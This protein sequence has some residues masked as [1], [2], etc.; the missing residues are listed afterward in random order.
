[1][2][3]SNYETT[4][5][6]EAVA[7]VFPPYQDISVY[8]SL[9]KNDVKKEGNDADFTTM[10]RVQLP[11]SLERD[12]NTIFLTKQT[13]G[14][15]KKGKD[16]QDA[17]QAIK[18]AESQ[19][20]F[21]DGSA[22]DLAPIENKKRRKNSPPAGPVMTRDFYA[23]FAEYMAK[24]SGYVNGSFHLARCLVS[25]SQNLEMARASNNLASKNNL[26][27]YFQSQSDEI[28][29]NIKD[30][31]RLDTVVNEY[32]KRLIAANTHVMRPSVKHKGGIDVL[33]TGLPPALPRDLRADPELSA[34]GTP[35]SFNP[36][37]AN[38]NVPVLRDATHHGMF[39]DPSN[40]KYVLPAGK[41]ALEYSGSLIRA[42]FGEGAGTTATAHQRIT[43][44][45]PLD[46]D[47][48]A[49]LREQA[50]KLRGL[51]IDP[52]VLAED[53][54]SLAGAYPPEVK[55]YIS[56]VAVL[57][58]SPAALDEK[59]IGLIDSEKST[60]S[61]EA[62]VLQ[63]QISFSFVL[64][65]P[66]E[67]VAFITQTPTNERPSFASLNTWV[68]LW[69]KAYFKRVGQKGTK[70]ERANGAVG[71]QPSKVPRYILSASQAKRL[72]EEREKLG[73][74]TEDGRSNDDHIFI[75]NIG[76]LNYLPK[77]QDMSVEN[78]VNYER[79]MDEALQLAFEAGAP[80]QMIGM[81][82]EAHPVFGINHPEFKTKR[83]GFKDTIDKYAGA[84]HA[85]SW[86]YNCIIV[87]N[88]GEADKTKAIDLSGSAAPNELSL[89]DY[90]RKP[91]GESMHKLFIMSRVAKVDKGGS[92]MVTPDTFGA[93][94]Q[95]SREMID[96]ALP[97]VH[98][99]QLYTYL[100]S[101][102]AVPS[103]QELVNRAASDMRVTNLRTDENIAKFESGFGDNQSLYSG[104]MTADLVVAAPFN[105]QQPAER[106]IE[107]LYALFKRAIIDASGLQGTNLLRVSAQ[108]GMDVT[109]YDRFFSPMRHN[110]HEFKNVY[111]YF[112]GRVFMH[113]MKAL[114]EADKKKMMV[115]NPSNPNKLLPYE[116]IVSEVMP[117]ATI[118]SK[119]IPNSDQIMIKGD[120]LAEKNRKN[121]SISEEDIIVP[122]SKAPDAG[123]PNDPEAKPGMQMFPHQ[124][125]GHKYLRNAPKFAVLDIAPGGGKTI[126]VLS[127]IAA[128]INEGR[129]KRPLIA[130]PQGLVRN[131][132][133]DMHK[134][135]QGQW[136]VIPITTQVVKTWS[137]ERLTDMI[138]NAPPNTVV[139]VGY[140][141]LSKAKQFPV[142]IGNHVE[143][144]S[145][146]LE[147]MKKFGFDYVAMDESHRVKNVDSQTHKVLK[148]LC[149]SS[150]IKYVRLATGTL[151]SNKLTD[152]VGQA[153]MFN[154][155]I[156]RTPEEYEMENQGKNDN[157]QWTWN[158]DTPKQARA[159]L[160]RHAAVITFKRKEWAFMLPLPIEEFIP[161]V[162][163]K[164]T[165]EEG[166]NAHQMMYDA[167]LKSTLDE[168]EEEMKKQD[169]KLALLKDGASEEE[170]GDEDSDD[171]EKKRKSRPRTDDEN[172]KDNIEGVFDKDGNL[173]KQGMDD[174][175]LE[176]LSKALGPYLQRLE[177][178]LTDPLGDEFGE[179][180]FGAVN[181]NFVSN[182]VLKVIER[183]KLNFI[184]MPWSA[185]QKYGRYDPQNP[186]DPD[187][188]RVMP[189]VCD[190]NG[191]RYV[192]KV[193]PAAET[194]R[195]LYYEKYQSNTPPDQD[196]EHWKEEKFGKV[197]V[198]CRYTRSVNAIYAALQKLAP[199]LAKAAVK[200][201]GE[202]PDKWKQLAK[203]KSTKI[204]PTCNTGVQILIANEQAIS[205]GHNLQMASRLIRVEAPWAPGELDQASARIFRP[206]P[207]G[208][209]GRE[210]IYLDW[211]LTD[212]SLEV[213]K[214]GRLISKMLTKAEFD[215]ADNPLYDN[216]NEGQLPVLSMGMDALKTQP[217]LDD[218]SDYT[219]AYGRLN[220][221]VGQEFRE[222][223]KTR[224]S[225]MFD[226]KPSPMMEK[227]TLIP[228]VPYVPDMAAPDPNK[229]GLRVMS[230]WLEDTANP[231]VANALRD[232]NKYLIGMWVH[233]EMGNG[234]IKSINF[235][236]GD[237]RISSIEVS[238]NGDPNEP[239]VGEVGLIHM[240]PKLTPEVQ[241]K[242]PTPPK[243]T[244]KQIKAMEEEKEK[245]RKKAER[246][247]RQIKERKKR[248]GAT[249]GRIKQ[250]ET[251]KKEYAKKPKTP[252]APKVAQPKT[253][254][255][256]AVPAPN[257]DIKFYPT[258]VNGFLALDA[259]VFDEDIVL[260]GK[261]K[262]K[263]VQDYA[264]VMIRNYKEFTQVMTFIKSKWH[265]APKL[266]KTLELLE[267]S[268]ETKGAKKFDANQ[269]P[270]K[271]FKNFL[272]M[273]EKHTPSKP[274]DETSS[275]K[276]ELKIYPMV[277]NG[278]LYLTADIA[279]NPFMK[280]WEEKKIPGT[281]IMWDHA[282]TDGGLWYRF[283][284]SNS[285]NELRA[286]IKELVDVGFNWINKD[287]F[288][289]AITKLKENHN[290]KR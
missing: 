44:V 254:K 189:D 188:K 175:T 231:D 9:S 288:E 279:T 77:R 10:M 213:A 200:F 204:D 8:E 290:L 172:I 148:Q 240:S 229:L 134:I 61:Q 27:A 228:F 201:H 263:H 227:S 123:W 103:F 31:D 13:A 70:Q 245:A 133:E 32:L 84:L 22:P 216:I 116:Y 251:F 169:S 21:G 158:K 73:F 112:G 18:N 1:M 5:V 210:Q 140:S 173:K 233:T 117:L 222:M 128:L 249:L 76:T 145:G 260:D 234:P 69:S 68:T 107:A 146:I 47:F 269:A 59:R 131:W 106:Q 121:D 90:L 99:R 136:N 109:E 127:D 187:I 257:D 53:V 162:M 58:A 180:Y 281:E 55:K 182:K 96:N 38:F 264:Y 255:A 147:F 266:L 171:A 262:F 256:P 91:F 192:L 226:I 124:I 12:F 177:M 199:D 154:S 85:Y 163:T 50:N 165:E 139:V 155:Q 278:K 166:G 97:F 118:F 42:I 151:I 92:P 14:N 243:L 49:V 39:A 218:I 88:S 272:A 17:Q 215:E 230:E 82:S 15:I 40:G 144:I 271:E 105:A 193:P 98:A 45:L 241:K 261:H 237:R 51:G 52:T 41:A 220:Y 43:K 236:R 104:I 160:A 282:A 183:I 217:T 74:Y 108:E 286:I 86:D 214:M 57:D 277:M 212:H 223:R 111:Q 284:T 195:A 274:K 224:S 225:K 120:E 28:I 289:R 135:T 275:G 242:L 276:P 138:V 235:T 83:R 71:I 72:A 207:A 119:Y 238:L 20:L 30:E 196:P 102:G 34:I 191:S 33:F 37:S 35:V 176:E 159:Q 65:I 16:K 60:V 247:E 232:P 143:K 130:C 206:D 89:T 137:F 62:L 79:V 267:N 174:A 23:I 11:E 287:E 181:E 100:L 259:E 48:K 246:E 198:F 66:A 157:G 94:S 252:S 248:E 250:L 219:S 2:K 132:V 164:D 87:S 194:S 75:S 168:I 149:T 26:A 203:F 179:K 202:V 258:L 4:S 205:E 270:V 150:Q 268:F 54:P 81:K 78:A 36:S 152:V 46:F 142:V 24:I 6:R 273:Y 161:V 113:M 170:S 101:E 280:R 126:L 110:L 80:V 93:K 122:G 95:D 64:N 56:I 3:I 283:A 29:K 167:V 19:I 115:V 63:P 129:V 253:P 239:Y 285:V 184:P 265:I 197:I 25:M 67:I 141:A 7:T 221:I 125:E 186:K 178:L 156:F 190:W 208:K 185:D 209:F 114:T 153:A 211:I 244:K